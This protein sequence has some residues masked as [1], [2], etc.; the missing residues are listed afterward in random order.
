MT[1]PRELLEITD[2]TVNIELLGNDHFIYQAWNNGSEEFLRQTFNQVFSDINPIGGI[3]LT[4]VDHY[5]RNCAV[6]ACTHGNGKKVI[7]ILDSRSFDVRKEEIL[8]ENRVGLYASKKVPSL[9]PREIVGLF[10]DSNHP[11]VPTVVVYDY[12]GRAYGEDVSTKELLKVVDVTLKK[13]TDLHKANISP[14]WGYSLSE[15][16]RA[17]NPY[18]IAIETTRYLFND[19]TRDGLDPSGKIKGLIENRWHP[20]FRQV[21]FFTLCH[22]DVTLSNIIARPEQ[23]ITL[24]DWTHARWDDPTY[25]MAYILFWPIMRGE[26]HKILDKFKRYQP[27]YGSMGL[28][29]CSRFPFY[30]AHKFIEYGRFKGLKWV[31]IGHQLLNLSNAEEAIKFAAKQSMG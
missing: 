31:N 10:T 8:R 12:L 24:I 14:K 4:P 7:K 30:L 1:Q 13:I 9:K 27:V 19:M 23:D 15:K 18:D 5:H 29:I 3:T 20:L 28:D 22:K 17:E 6:L 25:D 21:K 26:A 2:T 16:K 11:D